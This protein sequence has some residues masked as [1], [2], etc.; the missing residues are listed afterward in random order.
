MSKSKQLDDRPKAWFSRRIGFCSEEFFISSFRS[1]GPSSFHLERALGLRFVGSD[2][3]SWIR[4]DGKL[5]S[6]FLRSNSADG[7]SFQ[8]FSSFAKRISS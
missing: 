7:G 5:C 2:F 1:I 8:K 3:K 4:S 6:R